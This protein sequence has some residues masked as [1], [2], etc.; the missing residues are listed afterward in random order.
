M[1]KYYVSCIVLFL[2]LQF[3]VAWHWLKMLLMKHQWLRGDNLIH[4]VVYNDALQQDGSF[5]FKPMYSHIKNDIQSPDLAFINQESPLGGD[6]RPFSGFKNFNTPS[7]IA[8][9]VVE[10]GFDM[11]NGANNHSLDQGDEGVLNHLKAW[12]KFD[13][14]VLFTGIFNSKGILKRY[15]S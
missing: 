4:P 2:L 12:N 6:N 9:D 3:S 15:R 14:H 5:N 11:V 1:V 13:K 10:T 7:Q 8:Q